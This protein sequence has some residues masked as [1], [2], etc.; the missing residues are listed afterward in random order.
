[1]IREIADFI[2]LD[3]ASKITGKSQSMTEIETRHSFKFRQHLEG[4][5]V[6]KRRGC[7]EIELKKIIGS[8]GRYHEFKKQFK[9]GRGLRD[10]RLLSIL[11]A[12]KKGKRMPPISLY[13]IKEDFYIV[14]GHH[15]FRAAKELRLSTIEAHVVELLSQ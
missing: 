14:D 13:Q 4:V 9:I 10:E 15:R 1:M 7:A 12:M 2:P 6:P 5:Y 11:A 3:L 8:V